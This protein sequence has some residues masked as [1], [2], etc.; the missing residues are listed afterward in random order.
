MK[1]QIVLVRWLD[2]ITVTG[3]REHG[4]TGLVMPEPV[5]SVGFLHNA[6]DPSTVRFS[7]DFTPTDANGVGALPVGC[8]VKKMLLPF[9]DGF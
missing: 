8:V 5:V 1:P 7:M 3:W 9:P 4:K 6:D 2:P